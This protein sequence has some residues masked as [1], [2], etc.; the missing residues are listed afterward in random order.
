MVS[1]PSIEGNNQVKADYKS[2]RRFLQ[3]LG[4]LGAALPFAKAQLSRKPPRPRR[5]PIENV[6]ICCNENRTFDHYFG[7]APFAGRY[8]IPARYSQ[9]AGFPGVTIAPI[10]DN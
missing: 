4:L 8:G 7:K 2:R 10:D 1:E 3:G 9:P 5:L 6:L